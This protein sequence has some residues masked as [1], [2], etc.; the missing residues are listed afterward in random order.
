VIYIKN[1]D[2]HSELQTSSDSD[3]DDN[4]DIPADEF[5]DDLPF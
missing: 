5:G 1:N 2:A 3:K 4:I